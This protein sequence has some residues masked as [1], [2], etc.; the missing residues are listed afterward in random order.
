LQ[1]LSHALLKLLAAQRRAGTAHD[2][3]RGREAPPEEE[4]IKSRHELEG[5]EITGSSEDHN[6]TGI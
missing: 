3:T 5:S 1:R 4:V 2:A 6:S